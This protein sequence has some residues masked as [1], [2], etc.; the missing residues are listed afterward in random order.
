[1]KRRGQAGSAI[2][3]RRMKLKPYVKLQ[4]V[5]DSIN[6]EETLLGKHALDHVVYPGV[7]IAAIKAYWGTL[8]HK[9]TRMLKMLL[10]KAEAVKPKVYPPDAVMAEMGVRCTLVKGITENEMGIVA[11]HNLFAVGLQAIPMKQIRN[12]LESGR[13]KIPEKGSLGQAI[14]LPKIV[15]R[16]ANR[17]VS[18]HF[19]HN[20]KSVQMKLTYADLENSLYQNTSRNKAED[21]ANNGKHNN[22]TLRQKKQLNNG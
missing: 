18:R 14:S 7:N 3:K 22:V 21:E 4:N 19:T 15:E 13:L 11:L 20:G 1:M 8:C 10:Q 17:C 5:N 9:D 2:K 6:I 12:R 16:K